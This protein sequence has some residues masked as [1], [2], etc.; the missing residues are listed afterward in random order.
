MAAASSGSAAVA[1]PG[2]E[3]PLMADLMCGPNLPLTK[4]FLWCGWRTVSV[5]WLLDPAHDLSNPLRQKSLAGQLEETDF[6]AAAM[7]CS[8]KLR[9]REIPRTDDQHPSPSGQQTSP[10]GYQG[11]QSRT[12][13]G[14]TQTTRML[15]KHAE[16]GGPP[17]EELALVPPPEAGDD[18]VRTVEGHAIFRMRVC[19]GP[20]QTPVQEI[21]E[22]PPLMCHHTHR[23]REWEPQESSDGRWYPSKAE[24]EYTAVLAFSIAVAASWWAARVGKARLTVPRMPAI[25][26]VGRREHWL[27]FDGRALREWAMA[28]MA[29]SLGLKPPPLASGATVPRRVVILEVLYE[30]GTLPEDVVYVGRGHHDCLWDDWIS[31]SMSTSQA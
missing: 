3:P 8:T 27:E 26:T 14:W 25:E 13:L 11:C 12:R 21:E 22:W 16:G 1:L 20:E 23:P 2:G 30:D 28:P 10:W 9:A 4:A 18:G 24:A 31:C 19:G 7:D 29:V 6:I 5:D 15:R 17:M